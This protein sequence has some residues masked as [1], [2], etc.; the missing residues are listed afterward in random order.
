MADSLDD[1]VNRARA[2]DGDTVRTSGE[3][4]LRLQGVSASETQHGDHPAQAGAYEQKDALDAWLA[5]NVALDREVTGT[6]GSRNANLAPRDLGDLRPAGGGESATE[7]MI[8]RDLAAASPDL[9]QGQQMALA[10]KAGNILFGDEWMP[11]SDRAAADRLHARQQVDVADALQQTSR[12]AMDRDTRSEFEKGAQAGE[13]GT[14]AAFHGFR[15]LMSDALGDEAGLREATRDYEHSMRVQDLLGGPR[16]AS[17]EDIQT[18]G[19]FTDWAS[20]ALGQGLVSTAPSLIAGVA[21]GGVGAISARVAARVAADR[22]AKAFEKNAAASLV[23]ALPNLSVTGGTVNAAIAKATADVRFGKSLQTLLKYKSVPKLAAAGGAFVASDIVESGAIYNELAERGLADWRTALGYGSASAA[24]DVAGLA[25]AVGKV[26]PGAD[27]VAKDGITKILASG[28]V[29]DFLQSAGVEGTTEGLQEAVH[30][31]AIL[32]EDPTFDMSGP[33]AKSRILNAFAMGALTGGVIGGTGRV[34]GNAQVAMT[35]PKEPAAKPVVPPGNGAAATTGA[36]P[37]TDAT[38]ATV[39]GAPPQPVV[40]TPAVGAPPQ[41]TTGAA[42]AARGDEL[43]AVPRGAPPERVAAEADVNEKFIRENGHNS[44]ALLDHLA[45]TASRPED[46][47]LSTQLQRIFKARGFHPALVTSDREDL[48]P[49]V[50]DKM[51]RTLAATY[52]D[53]RNDGKGVVLA[54]SSTAVKTSGKGQV[55]TDTETLL[56]EYLHAG[57]AR[58]YNRPVTALDR[59]AS[60]QIKSVAEYLKRIPRPK[61]APE[62]LWNHVTGKNAGDELISIVKTSPEFRKVLNDIK[63][64]SGETAWQRFVSAVLKA[65]GINAKSDRTAASE[66][67]AA[68]RHYLE[69][70]DTPRRPGIE[71][72]MGER[73]MVGEEAKPIDDLLAKADARLA[74]AEDFAGAKPGSFGIII[75]APRR[76]TKRPNGGVDRVLPINARWLPADEHY[77][78]AVQ[79][80]LATHP[81]ATARVVRLPADARQRD[82]A[83]RQ[84][85]NLATEPVALSTLAD[86]VPAPT[87]TTTAGEEVDPDIADAMNADTVF[88]NEVFNPDDAAEVDDEPTL[89]GVENEDDT[90]DTP[91]AVEET[92][93]QHERDNADTDAQLVGEEKQARRRAAT[94]ADKKIG[95]PRLLERARAINVAENPELFI[96]LRAPTAVERDGQLVATEGRTIPLFVPDLQRFGRALR[97]NITGTLAKG[98][99]AADNG[100]I[101]V[102]IALEVLSEP[103]MWPRRPATPADLGVWPVLEMFTV[104]D[105]KYVDAAGEPVMVTEP[106]RT[107][108]F[109]TEKGQKAQRELYFLPFDRG[110]AAFWDALQHKIVRQE[111]GKTF[112]ELA[113]AVL[114]KSEALKFDD[115]KPKKNTPAERDLDPALTAY[116]SKSNVGRF[117]AA[118]VAATKLARTLDRPVAGSTPEI[119]DALGAVAAQASKVVQMFLNINTEV[120]ALRAQMGNQL[121]STG[122]I[123][124]A[125]K[126]LREKREAEFKAVVDR[127]KRLVERFNAKFPGATQEDRAAINR[128]ASIPVTVNAYVEKANMFVN[129]EAK[130]RRGEATGEAAKKVTRKLVRSAFYRRLEALRSLSS[131][132]PTPEA[133][134]IIP[135][136]PTTHIES[137]RRKSDA[138]AAVRA[139]KIAEKEAELTDAQRGGKSARELEREKLDIERRAE[140]A[141]AFIQYDIERLKEIYGED[142]DPD[143]IDPAIEPATKDAAGIPISYD[144]HSSEFTDKIKQRVKAVNPQKSVPTVSPGIAALNFSDSLI[145][146]LLSMSEAVPVY[147]QVH[148]QTTKELVQD[149]VRRMSILTRAVNTAGASVEAKKSLLRERAWVSETLNKLQVDGKAGVVLLD[150]HTNTIHIA[151]GDMALADEQGGLIALGH[152]FGHVVERMMLNPYMNILPMKDGLID[153]HALRIQ[154]NRYSKIDGN[155]KNLAGWMRETYGVDRPTANV[156]AGFMDNVTGEPFHEWMATQWL[157]YVARTRLNTAEQKSPGVPSY[158]IEFLTNMAKRL[159]GVAKVIAERLGIKFGGKLQSFTRDYFSALVYA[160]TGMTA[161]TA[162]HTYAP[163]QFALENDA[164]VVRPFALREF[165]PMYMTRDEAWA[166]VGTDAKE[167]FARNVASRKMYQAANSRLSPFVRK[168]L[169]TARE[170]LAKIVMWNTAYMKSMKN[171][172]P[173]LKA[174]ID[175]FDSGELHQ[176]WTARRTKFWGQYLQ[177]THGLNNEQKQELYKLLLARTNFD[178]ATIA[179][180]AVKAA[181]QAVKTMTREMYVDAAEIIAAAGGKGFLETEFRYDADYGIQRVWNQEAILANESGF[182]EMLK[183]NGVDGQAAMA[184]LGKVRAGMLMEGQGEQLELNMDIKPG[185]AGTMRGRELPPTMKGVEP[186][187]NPSMDD[188]MRTYISQMTK[189]AALARYFGGTHTFKSGETAFWPTAKINFALNEA[190]MSGMAKGQFSVPMD[191][192]DLTYMATKAF[193]ALLGRLG[194]DISP[195]ARKFI[196]TTQAF[197]NLLLLPFS[198]LASFPDMAGLLIRSRDLQM[199]SAAFREYLAGMNRDEIRETAELLGFVTSEALD[200]FMSTM[201]NDGLHDTSWA[202]KMNHALFKWNQQQR[203]TKFVRTVATSVAKKW[204]RQQYEAARAGDEKAL[205]LL[206]EVLP[207]T[208]S[209]TRV[210]DAALKMTVPQLLAVMDVWAAHDFNLVALNRAATSDKLQDGGTVDAAVRNADRVMQDV[211]AIFVNQAVLNPHAAERPVWASDPKWALVFHLKQFMYSFHKVILTRLAG[212]FAKAYANKDLGYAAHTASYLVPLLGLAAAGLVIRNLLQYSLVGDEPPEER[213]MDGGW[214]YIQQ[215]L[216]RSGIYGLAQFA[217]D[218]DR[219]AEQG[220]FWPAALLGPAASK[221]NDFVTAAAVEDDKWS[222]GVTNEVAKLFPPFSWSPPLRQNTLDSME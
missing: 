133:T 88:D 113:N 157:R 186:F 13:Y 200:E 77:A 189:T 193:P 105:G 154:F 204:L 198:T 19:D 134:H 195:E 31:A 182:V 73:F 15:A 143:N 221:V 209:T 166:E 146:T 26:L 171:L 211:F 83:M 212:D 100:H 163:L 86:A 151:L 149:L 185:T 23:G 80:I 18:F 153:T 37:A 188:V 51:D 2:L 158:T 183:A 69:V 216:Q 58:A 114:S 71:P 8:S 104:R 122:E 214:A 60:A 213:T 7:Y 210:Q 155:D 10:G 57:V 172:T 35:R 197:L 215:I 148:L 36:V 203:Y 196:T 102:L 161:V 56:H 39:A 11:A 9:N 159:A 137:Q 192:K 136:Y 54:R 84:R 165:G 33:D 110:N 125:G 179:D 99:E 194:S 156:I 190:R 132:M 24:L 85:S 187:L 140:N 98:A 170:G 44:E 6:A 95:I 201:Y 139:E 181:G 135:V 152:E 167:F 43:N 96:N 205:D 65:L 20:G 107:T 28:V 41:P 61:N 218:V 164:I 109:V 131:P 47:V 103:S 145:S 222:Q 49:E 14:K 199:T 70:S 62:A 48:D 72:L 121:K 50:R 175:I 68:V 130:Q 106:L 52:I 55:G 38:T 29:K 42:P 208:T 75:D 76:V 174:I 74:Q 3:R 94:L 117:V 207:Y 123:L 202:G 5:R 147:G 176:F 89:A 206:R 93:A 82:L 128:L 115:L 97:E 17:V 92:F 67:E 119:Q 22:A 46:R 160:H 191:E 16:V 1:F 126:A 180:P 178:K 30:M 168:T 25:F 21:T 53:N 45:Q 32:H 141:S 27:E 12:A 144:K 112:G 63:M 220:G 81:D 120:R 173:K 150:P 184:F 90:V 66:V 217:M 91:G 127:A 129:I 124:A 219:Q 111:S 162:G 64:P 34:V 169:V 116:D 4:D 101:D 108:H 78:A 79:E 40:G 59:A 142:V 118:H 177:A 87:R 138:A